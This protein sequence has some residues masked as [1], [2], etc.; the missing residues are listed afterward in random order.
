[1]GSLTICLDIAEI[2]SRQRRGTTKLSGTIRYAGQKEI[3]SHSI[4]IYMCLRTPRRPSWRELS[5]EALMSMAT[6]SGSPFWHPSA[7]RPRSTGPAYCQLHGPDALDE[8]LHQV[9]RVGSLPRNTDPLQYSWCLC[10]N[11]IFFLCISFWPRCPAVLL[12]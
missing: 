2:I 1:M 6:K 12:L 4:S 10:K 7:V 8:I 9:S 3:I 11:Q 5:L